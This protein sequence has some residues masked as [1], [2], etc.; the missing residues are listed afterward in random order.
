MR[1]KEGVSKGFIKV[2]IVAALITFVAVFFISF[3]EINLQLNNEQSR[4]LS[5]GKLTFPFFF[6][7]KSDI[8]L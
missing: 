4:T 2:P 5:S 6:F 1:W 8:T 3:N 7:K